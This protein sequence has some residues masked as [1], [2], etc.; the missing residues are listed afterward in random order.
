VAVHLD[1]LAR[2]LAEEDRVPF[3][4]VERRDLAVLLDLALADS[5]DLALLRLFLGGVRDDDPADFL[6]PLVDALH[7]DPIVEGTDLHGCCSCGSGH[8]TSTSDGCG[9]VVPP[10]LSGG[11]SPACFEK[12]RKFGVNEA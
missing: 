9:A 8:R 2:V 4:D 10:R 6:L 1:F 11:G 7:D 3:L 5:D 12:D